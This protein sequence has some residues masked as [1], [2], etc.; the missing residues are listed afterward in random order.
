MPRVRDVSRLRFLRIRRN[1]VLKDLGTT[2]FGGNGSAGAI[3]LS[4]RNGAL[5][6]VSGLARLA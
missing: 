4:G 6:T 2:L 1:G 5:H 3:G